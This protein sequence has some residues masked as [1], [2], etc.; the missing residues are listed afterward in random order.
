[1][2]NM[3][4]MYKLYKHPPDSPAAP[5]FETSDGRAAAGQRQDR[6]KP[7]IGHSLWYLGAAFFVLKVMEKPVGFSWNFHGFQMIQSR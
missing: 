3:Y 2:Y 4:N 7:W 1:M 5:G 6:A